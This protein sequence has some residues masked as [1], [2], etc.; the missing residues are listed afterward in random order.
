MLHTYSFTFC[1][2]LT[3][4]SYKLV[5]KVLEKDNEV[6]DNNKAKRPLS[7]S[8]D[9]TKLIY[10]WHPQWDD[11]KKKFLAPTSRNCWTVKMPKQQSRLVSI[12]LVSAD[13]WAAL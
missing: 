13:K 9:L 7:W 2:Q 3:F 11:Y 6:R 8:A 1:L 10:Y 4:L 5:H 12:L